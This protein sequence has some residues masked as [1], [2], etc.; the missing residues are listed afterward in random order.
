M[1]NSR[2]FIGGN[3]KSNCSLEKAEKLTK[4]LISEL[5]KMDKN[6]KENKY[7]VISPPFVYLKEIN[8]LVKRTK[9]AKFNFAVSAQNC[10]ETGNG[11]Y[12]GEISTEMLKSIDVKWVIVGHSERRSLFCENDNT[13]AQKISLCMKEKLSVIACIGETL[14][15]RKN[16]QLEEILNRQLEGIQNSQNL[17]WSKIVIAYEPV[18]AIGTGEVATPEQ[19]QKVHCF[20]RKWLNKRVSPEIANTIRIIYGG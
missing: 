2:I 5:S 13:I 9:F 20:I 4:E 10:S 19:A 8:E 12:T 3:W 11:A 7:V 18:W 15:E 1:D 17:D 14:K 6:M 16:G